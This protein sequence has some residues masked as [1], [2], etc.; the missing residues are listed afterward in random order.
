MCVCKGWHQIKARY[1]ALSLVYYIFAFY[2]FPVPW[3]LVNSPTHGQDNLVELGLLTGE[4]WDNKKIL[5]EYVKMR[6]EQKGL[7]FSSHVNP[8]RDPEEEKR[9]IKARRNPDPEVRVAAHVPVVEVPVAAPAPGATVPVTEA[10]AAAVPVTGV[11][12]L[13]L[14][15]VEAA[16]LD[17]GVP[18]PTLGAMETEPG[19]DVTE[20]STVED[21]TGHSEHQPA[22]SDIF[23]TLEYDNHGR[24]ILAPTPVSS[25]SSECTPTSSATSSPRRS[26]SSLTPPRSSSPEARMDTSSSPIRHL[27]P[28]SSRVIHESE[29]PKSGIGKG[30]LTLIRNKLV[31]GNSATIKAEWNTYKADPDHLILNWNDLKC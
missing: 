2:R 14:P 20:P 1:G 8:D 11:N 7:H 22:S 4:A 28:S 6:L 18:E 25:P 19:A 29:R 12:A 9:K 16:A 5:K 23:R 27:R 10:E 26:T 30:G 24:I 17:N 31:S 21:V 15:R 13:D 3:R